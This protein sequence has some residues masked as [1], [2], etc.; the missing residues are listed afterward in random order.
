MPFGTLI[1]MLHALQH[2]TVNLILVHLKIIVIMNQKLEHVIVFIADK[3]TLWASFFTYFQ[4]T[5]LIRT[6]QGK[7]SKIGS[8]NGS[9]VQ[10]GILNIWTIFSIIELVKIVI[11][12]Y[13]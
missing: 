8:T 5:D 1:H 12:Y 6:G 7:K 2:G 3:L 9:L 13:I 11:F 4:N 10:K